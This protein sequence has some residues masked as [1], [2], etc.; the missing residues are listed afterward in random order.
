MQFGLLTLI[1]LIAS[2]AALPFERTLATRRDTSVIDVYLTRM[3]ADLQVLKLDL[4]GLPS[5]GSR[6]IANQRALNLLDELKKLGRTMEAGIN[7]VRGG[8]SVTALETIGLTGSVTS[9]SS[10]VSDVTAGFNTENTKRMIWFAGKKEAQN[11][12]AQELA[13]NSKAY[14]NFANAL[15]SKLPVLEQ[16]LAGILKSGVGALVEPAVAV[17]LPSLTTTWLETLKLTVLGLQL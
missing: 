15:I 5:G 2:V 10:L 3:S 11:S 17:C 9:M 13:R 12:F 1:V 14:S 16:G 8:P 4:R 6:E 7:A